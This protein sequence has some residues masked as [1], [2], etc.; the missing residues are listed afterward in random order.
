MN[1]S[2]LGARIVTTYGV[3]IWGICSQF[4]TMRLL[5]VVRHLRLVAMRELVRTAMLLDVVV[6]RNVL[7]WVGTAR[8]WLARIP[9]R[10][11]GWGPKAAR[12][13]EGGF[14]DNEPADQENRAAG[15]TALGAGRVNGRERPIKDAGPPFCRVDPVTPRRRRIETAARRRMTHCGYSAAARLA[16]RIQLNAR[17]AAGIAV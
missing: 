17:E 13:S 4:L 5:P 2:L 1:A 12:I 10:R 16:A 9:P 15:P 8:S 3:V 6:S 7:L 14:A 11:V